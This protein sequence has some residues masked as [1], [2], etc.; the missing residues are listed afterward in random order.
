MSPIRQAAAFG[1]LIGAALKI[2]DFVAAPSYVNFGG[3]I[4]AAAIG[5]LLAAV[6]HGVVTGKQKPKV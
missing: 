3:L 2:P 4:A 1:A 6:A 5:A